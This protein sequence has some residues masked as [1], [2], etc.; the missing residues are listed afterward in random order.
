MV[1]WTPHSPP[2]LLL[3]PLPTPTSQNAF[4]PPIFPQQQQAPFPQ[5]RKLPLRPKPQTPSAATRL[6]PGE[7]RTGS[8]ILVKVL[9]R[10]GVTTGG[11]LMEIHRGSRAPPQ[12]ATSSP[13]TSR[14]TRPPPRAWHAAPASPECASPP[15]TPAPPTSSPASRHDGLRPPRFRSMSRIG[16]VCFRWELQGNGESE[17]GLLWVSSSA[18]S[19]L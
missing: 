19:V 13:A 18:V 16:F 7:P 6:H 12:S 11:A 8:G 17:V 2:Y 15:S 4:H 1:T 14:A 9:E 5:N 3:L 10:E